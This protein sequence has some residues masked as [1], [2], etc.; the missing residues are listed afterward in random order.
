MEVVGRRDGALICEEKLLVGRD[1]ASGFVV[2][3]VLREVREGGEVGWVTLVRDR[4]VVISGESRFAVLV[5]D[6]H[7]TWLGPPEGGPECSG[8]RDLSSPHL[9]RPLSNPTSYRQPHTYTILPN[10]NLTYLLKLC[11]RQNQTCLHQ[12][13]TTPA[14]QPHPQPPKQPP[15]PRH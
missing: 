15:R 11:V 13:H 8:A 4:G 10:H 6:G 5:G 1:M 14:P 3:G 7:R 12:Q 2:F 9:V